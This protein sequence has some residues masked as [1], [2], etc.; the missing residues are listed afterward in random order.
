MTDAQVT[1]GLIRSGYVQVQELQNT[2]IV[3]LLLQK[4]MITK[5]DLNEGLSLFNL[6][7]AK[8]VINPDGY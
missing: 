1:Q 3:Q 8:G 6:L 2:S 7:L 4:K 5:E